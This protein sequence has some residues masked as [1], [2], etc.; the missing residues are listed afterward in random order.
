MCLLPVFYNLFLTYKGSEMFLFCVC[1]FRL[2]GPDPLDY[3]SMYANAGNPQEN[4]PPHW[5][6]IRYIEFFYLKKVF[7]FQ[8]TSHRNLDDLLKCS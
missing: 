5:H 8:V 3:I 1:F 6:Y 7:Q 4:I 2:G